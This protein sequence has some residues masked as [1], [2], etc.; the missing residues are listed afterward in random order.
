M[1]CFLTPAA[2]AIV[3]TSVRKKIPA[4]YHFDWLI[5]MLWGG[6]IMLIVDH[7]LNGEIIFYPPFLTANFY[8]VFSEIIR[9]GLPMTISII[10]MWGIIVLVANKLV[11][12]RKKKAKMIV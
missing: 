7:L 6:V 11:R 12:I 2:A 5:M 8:E 10:L 4:K 3:T 1:A 9:I